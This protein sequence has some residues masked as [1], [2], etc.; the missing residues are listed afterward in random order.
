MSEVHSHP[1]ESGTGVGAWA[2]SSQQN[3]L[4]WLVHSL[5]REVLLVYQLSREYLHGF[6]LQEEFS[7]KRFYKLMHRKSYPYES[8]H[9]PL[10]NLLIDVFCL[11]KCSGDSLRCEREA[12]I[13]CG[14][15]C[16]LCSAH[17]GL[18]SMGLSWDQTGSEVYTFLHH[19]PVLQ[20]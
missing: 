13:T 2:C 19:S 12:V 16:V 18:N 10:M 6:A 8:I 20:Q 9:I 14:S 1:S 3:L 15:L 11:H 4:G 17:G 7:V 5:D